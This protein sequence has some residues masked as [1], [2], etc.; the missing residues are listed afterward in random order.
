MEIVI[1]SDTVFSDPVIHKYLQEDAVFSL[2]RYKNSGTLPFKQLRMLRGHRVASP[3]PQ[4]GAAGGLARPA[5]KH[6]D[7]LGSARRDPNQWLQA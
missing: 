3:V 2:R 6:P 1:C 7:Y 5:S 4:P